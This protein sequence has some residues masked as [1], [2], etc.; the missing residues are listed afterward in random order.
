MG[1]RK[2][3][4][5]FPGTANFSMEFSVHSVNNSHMYS[6]LTK[7]ITELYQAT[8]LSEQ[9]PY[10]KSLRANSWG[11]ANQKPAYKLSTNQKKAFMIQSLLKVWQRATQLQNLL[12][13]P[14]EKTVKKL[15][16]LISNFQAWDFPIYSTLSNEV[17]ISVFFANIYFE[18]YFEIFWEFA[19][20]WRERPDAILNFWKWKLQFFRYFWL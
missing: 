16:G 8:K 1:K 9:L 20:F 10:T 7:R 19:S 2:S 12:D 4:L 5:E 3:F 17:N 6:C 18:E 11:T 15:F 14:C 13:S